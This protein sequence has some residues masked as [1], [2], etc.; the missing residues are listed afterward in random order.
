MIREACSIARDRELLVVPSVKYH[1]PGPGETEWRT[2]EYL[3]TTRAILDAWQSSN[4]NSPMPLEKDFSPTLAGSDR[5]SG[6]PWFSIGCG[7]IPDLI[8]A[9]TTG[10]GQVKVGLKL[11]NSLDDD[12]FQ[13]AMLAEVHR[14]KSPADF[15][16][17]ANRLFDPNRVFERKQGVAYGG[18][19]LSDRNL[20]V[21]SALRTSSGSAARLAAIRWKSAARATSARAGSPLSM[22]CGDAR[23][24]RFTHFSSFPRRNTRCSRGPKSRKLCTGFTS[25][26]TMGLSFGCFMPRRRLQLVANDGGVRFLDLARRGAESNLTRRDLDAESS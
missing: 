22:R 4:G 19:D 10:P 11:F 1:L 26:R 24:F 20:R 15:L 25:I 23:A 5:A 21:L 3:E 16:V 8:R 14:G 9:A 12:S 13:L 2:E 18:P 6:K 7:D 17:Y